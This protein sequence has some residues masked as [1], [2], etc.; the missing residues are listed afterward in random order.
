MTPASFLDRLESKVQQ[1]LSSQYVGYLLGAGAS[2]VGGNGYPLA[3]ELWEYISTKIRSP[4]RE[5]IQ[6]KLDSDADGIEHALDLLDDGAA[7][8]KLHRHLVTEAIAEHFLSITPPTEFHGLS[9]G[10]LR[11]K[12][13]AFRSFA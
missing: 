8:E 11:A 9:D 4:E 3:S 12:N 10:L 1:Q 6:N 5:E 13:S 7:I 2:Y